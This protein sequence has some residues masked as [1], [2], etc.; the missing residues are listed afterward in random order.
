MIT[1]NL[2]DV[3]L[4]VDRPIAQ[5]RGIQ[6][7]FL[8]AVVRVGGAQISKHLGRGVRGDGLRQ[9]AIDPQLVRFKQRSD[10]LGG[11][12]AHTAR[13]SHHQAGL[14]QHLFPGAP[15]QKLVR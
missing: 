3:G 1:K 2:D 9:K 14:F 7:S 13:R 11:I 15:L 5:I 10:L 8:V 6:G 12:G 4:P